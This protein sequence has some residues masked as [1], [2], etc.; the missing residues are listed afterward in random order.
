MQPSVSYALFIPDNS[1]SD[2][3]LNSFS[4]LNI[5]LLKSSSKTFCWSLFVVEPSGTLDRSCFPFE[6]ELASDA[7]RRW[8]YLKRHEWPRN[9]IITF[10]THVTFL[11]ELNTHAEDDDIEGK[12]KIGQPRLP[13]PFSLFLMIRK[14]KVESA[15]E[16]VHTK[17]WNKKLELILCMKLS[18]P[19]R[20]KH[21]CMYELQNMNCVILVILHMSSMLLYLHLKLAL[22]NIKR[23]GKIHTNK[24]QFQLFFTENV[25]R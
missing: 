24:L 5:V 18:V 13:F 15:V 2:K 3:C 7:E 20:M 1:V 14:L 22:H 6:L 16:Y 9:P 12:E 23:K 8:Y 19:V 4:S 25:I 11:Y 10:L 21:I 17:K